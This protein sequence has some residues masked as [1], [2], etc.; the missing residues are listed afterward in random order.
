MGGTRV[1]CTAS[2]DTK[3]PDWLVGKGQGWLT[4]EYNMLPGSTSPR[5]ARDKGKTD[6]RS[7]EIQRLIG[8]SLRAV[9]DLKQL[10]GRALWIDCDVLDADGGTRTASITG[11][12]VAAIDAVSQS[13]LAPKAPLVFTDSVAAVSVGII[14]GQPRLDLD[15]REDVD[16]DVDM[17]VVMTGS[18]KFIEVQGT[19]EHAPFSPAQL[20]SLLELA[21]AGIASLTQ[22][23][24]RSIPDRWP[25]AIAGN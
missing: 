18:G 13:D 12:Y 7:V 24:F 4:A 15:Y 11:A 3:I 20:H 23:Q 6:G 8:R 17:N 1:L 10:D 14:A 2:I 5:K 22:L 9:V 19:A 25:L 16:A 21:T